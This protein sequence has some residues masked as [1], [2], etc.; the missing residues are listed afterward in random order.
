MTIYIVTG[1]GNNQGE[2]RDEF[3]H[4]STKE[5]AVAYAREKFQLSEDQVARLLDRRAVSLFKS[6]EVEI[7]SHH[8]VDI[9]WISFQ[10]AELDP[11]LDDRPIV[12][13]QTKALAM[14]HLGGTAEERK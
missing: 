9:D 13:Q 11:P 4:F 1:S 8:H 3:W 14:E 2:V 10:E 5:R 6:V 12:D 7:A